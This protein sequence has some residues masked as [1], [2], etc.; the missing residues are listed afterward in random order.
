MVALINRPQPF[1]GDARGHESMIAAT[2]APR[3]AKRLPALLPDLTHVAVRS[4][5]LRK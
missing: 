1:K 3:H 2:M 4:A 5:T